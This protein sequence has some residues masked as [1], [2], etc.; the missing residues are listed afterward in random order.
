MLLLHRHSALPTIGLA[1]LVLPCAASL[2]KRILGKANDQSLMSFFSL[3]WHCRRIDFLSFMKGHRQSLKTSAETGDYVP[4]VINYYNLMSEV[5]TLVSGPYWHFVPMFQ[6]VSREESHKRF[7]HTLAEYLAAKKSDQILEIGCGYGEMGRQ[8][9]KISG[10]S[11]TGL[12]MA[13]AEIVGGNERI[14]EAN[15]QDR[16]KMVQGNYN[17]VPF[18]ACSFDKIFGVYTLKYSSDLKTVFDEAF[19]CLKPGGLFLSYEIL[20]TDKYDRND[21]KHRAY[22]EDISSSTCMPPLW[23][24]QAMRDAASNAG[25]VK[26]DEEDIGSRSDAD[27]WYS[28]FTR[29]GIHQ[30]LTFPLTKVLVMIAEKIY[31]LPAGF[32][33]FYQ[34]LL[35]H[36][37][38]DFVNAG[39]LGIISGTVVMTWRKPY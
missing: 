14:K 4:G 13:D 16:C 19:R 12:T 31:I 1:A 38:T 20:V 18:G 23:P 22:V 27:P 24:A 15:L 36:P 17:E 5:I 8:V 32:T 26:S 35:V 9:A 33:D 21:P 37:T 7:H 29:R 10:A 28:C 6:G 25:F 39:R 2:L 34:H 3:F 11:V 30:V